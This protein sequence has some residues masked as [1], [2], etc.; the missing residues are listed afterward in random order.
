[1]A[2]NLNLG[3]NYNIFEDTKLCFA[4]IKR[5]YYVITRSSRAQ[6]LLIADVFEA[7]H[8]IENFSITL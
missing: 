4:Y 7:S 2:R 5:N 8:H 1:M 6:S 3:Y